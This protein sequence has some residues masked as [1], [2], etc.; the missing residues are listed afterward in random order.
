MS[1]ANDYLR[2]AEDDGACFRQIRSTGLWSAADRD[3]V[4]IVPFV[5][6]AMSIAEAARLYCEDK[7][8]TPSHEILAR[9]VAKYRGYH[10][11]A[12]FWQGFKACQRDSVLR[13][14]PYRDDEG[15]KAQAWDR[16]ANA[17]MQYQ[18][19]MHHVATTPAE[20]DEAEPGWLVRLL[21]TGRR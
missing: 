18:R 10:V 11:L 3:G 21:R 20:A 15:V 7:G 19:A 14:N 2:L 12:E 5:D 17:A 16:G 6:G 8:L 4:V 13:C 1:E 9:I